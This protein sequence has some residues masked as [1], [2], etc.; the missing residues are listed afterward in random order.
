MPEQQVIFVRAAKT[1]PETVWRFFHFHPFKDIKPIVK[2]VYFDFTAGTISTWRIWKPEHGH[3]PR[4]KPDKVT[5]ITPKIQIRF[6]DGKI[7]KGPPRA[8]VLGLYDYIKN[9]PSKSVL[10]L[11][12][13]SHGDYQGPITWAESFEE[14]KIRDNIKAD[15]DPHD[16]EFRLRDFYG[17]NPLAGKEGKRFAN[18]FVPTPF[19]KLWGCN[20]D[21][22]YRIL[23]NRYIDEKDAVKKKIHMKT[24]LEMLDS[25]YSILL[26]RLLNN[27]VW[28]APLG[29]GSNPYSSQLKYVGTFPPN[30][31]TQHWWRIPAFAK[32]YR[33]VFRQDLH[34]LVDATHYVGHHG[35]WYLRACR[36]FSLEQRINDSV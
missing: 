13:F 21:R 36:E 19:V 1:P 18:A 30:L 27:Y 11:Q 16:S 20:A 28:A 14:E 15:R 3:A 29:W 35:R 33:R 12:I 10:S 24:Y 22:R 32:K 8:S 9:Q 17:E 6:D 4:K 31:R 23:L 25:T 26:S 5:E 2:L 34:A 7:D